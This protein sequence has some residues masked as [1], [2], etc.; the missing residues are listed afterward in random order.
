[1]ST[2][3]KWAL[4]L[5]GGFF[6]AWAQ[7]SSVPASSFK[8]NFPEKDSP[9][10]L[11]SAN[12]PWGESKTEARGGALVLDLRTALTLRNTTQRRIRGITLLV[13][14]QEVTPGAKAR[15]PCPAWTSSPAKL[16]P[17]A[18]IFG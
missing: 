4:L 10:S 3:N 2:R 8:I 12:L 16:S 5:L 9:V 14:A 13:Q 1:M 7:D 17:S 11:V 18:S 6:A 15:S